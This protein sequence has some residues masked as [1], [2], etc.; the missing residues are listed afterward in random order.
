MSRCRGGVGPPPRNFVEKRGESEEEEKKRSLEEKGVGKREPSHPPTR[1]VIET[2]E[3]TS[4]HFTFC[5]LR[6]G[7]LLISLSFSNSCVFI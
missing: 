1:S 3:E 2:N 6:T 4:R 5:F 7:C